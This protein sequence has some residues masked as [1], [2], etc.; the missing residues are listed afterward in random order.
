MGA[1]INGVYQAA[2]SDVAVSDDITVGDDATVTDDL[3]VGGKITLTG[4]D[5]IDTTANGDIQLLP[6]GTGIS[7]VGDAAA[8]SHSLAANDDLFVSG[9]FEVD[10]SA[11][12]DADVNC[13]NWVYITQGLDVTD[14]NVLY[15]GSHL[16]SGILYDEN[17]NDALIIES[18]ASTEHIVICQKAD[19]A[20]NWSLPSQS[21]PTLTIQS[22]DATSTTD[23]I[24]FYHNQTDACINWGA[25]VLDF[26]GGSVTASTVTHDEYWEVKIGGVSKKIMLGA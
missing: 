7:K 24:Y 5:V 2:F 15:F 17:T 10:G 4:G 9:K 21:D 16:D 19:V 13:A 20:T 3:T 6:N 14:N 18:P 26:A 22:A 8:T 1:I 23:R 12:F 25:G 11:Y